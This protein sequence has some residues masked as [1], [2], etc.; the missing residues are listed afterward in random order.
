MDY[1]QGLL[2]Q[3]EAEDVRAHLETCAECRGVLEQEVKLARSLAG[4]PSVKPPD[5]W[6]AVQSGIKPQPKPV[7]P[8]GFR[9]GVLTRR[10]V[11]ASAVF[12]FLIIALF[13]AG[14]WRTDETATV[15]VPEKEAIRQAAALIQVQPAAST[16]DTGTT[17][18]MIQVLE[19]E[20]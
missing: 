8:I 4:V 5:V 10:L 14:P 20:L 12:I 7:V 17:D 3:Q 16:S 13:A 1:S 6:S 15:T 9:L 11:A 2:S 19:D 18:A